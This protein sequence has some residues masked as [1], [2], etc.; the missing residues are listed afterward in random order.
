MENER[1]DVRERLRKAAVMEDGNERPILVVR[2]AIVII[3]M[4]D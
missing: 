2:P 4:Q 1:F 3:E